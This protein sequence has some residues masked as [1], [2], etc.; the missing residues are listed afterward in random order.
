MR[1]IK[2][3]LSLFLKSAEEFVDFIE[4]GG[5]LFHRLGSQDEI[6]DFKNLR[7]IVIIFREMCAVYEIDFLKLAIKNIQINAVFC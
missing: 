5:L 2:K 4:A 6:A 7:C 1:L 3:S